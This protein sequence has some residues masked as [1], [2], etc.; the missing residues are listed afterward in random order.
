MITLPTNSRAQNAIVNRQPTFSTI[1]IGIAKRRAMK[2]GI[3]A[4]AWSYSMRVN[5]RENAKN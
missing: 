4:I 2:I 5:R 3:N 1:S